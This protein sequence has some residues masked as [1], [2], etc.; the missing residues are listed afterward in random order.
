VPATHSGLNSKPAKRALAPATEYAAGQR[1][2]ELT[3]QRAWYCWL[4]SACY[5]WSRLILLVVTCTQ[6]WSHDDC[7]LSGQRLLLA[8]RTCV[9][10]KNIIFCFVCSQNLLKTRVYRDFVSS[11]SVKSMLT[12]IS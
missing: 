9:R 3:S 10:W 12:S 4:A 5:Y 1:A 8:T 7:V 6:E 11:N 2:E